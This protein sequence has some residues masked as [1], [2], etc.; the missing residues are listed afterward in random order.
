M[1]ERVNDIDMIWTPFDSSAV[2]L[3]STPASKSAKWDLGK[4]EGEHGE[5]VGESVWE[6]K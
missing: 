3:P 5:A 1:H 4:A 2:F 6:R